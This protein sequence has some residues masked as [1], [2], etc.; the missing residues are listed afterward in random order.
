M[1]DESK[2][3]FNE[4]MNEIS[5][6][7]GFYERCCRAGVCAGAQWV[8]NH[9]GVVPKYM[10]CPNVFGIVDAADAHAQSLWDAIFSAPLTRDD[11]VKTILRDELSGAQMHA[12][13]HHVMFIAR[14]GWSRYREEMT[15][16]IAIYGAEPEDEEIERK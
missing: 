7:G 8:A 14:N 6:F 11:G 3:Q 5:G 4:L 16:P 13:V 9:P 2:F 10:E 12:I 15:Q 1:V